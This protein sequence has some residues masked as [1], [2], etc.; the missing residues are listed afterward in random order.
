MV[1][2]YAYEK[3]RGVP[4]STIWN[5]DYHLPLWQK[6]FDIPNSIPLLLV[7][8][9]A[10]IFWKKTALALMFAS[11]LIH[12]LLDFTVHHD[13]AHRHFFPLSNFR[14]ASPI[15]YWDPKFY[16]K[17]FGTLEIFLFVAGSIYLWIAKPPKAKILQLSRLRLVVLMTSI[18]YAGFFYFVVTHWEGV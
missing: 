17:I 18:T 15:S 16:G 1:L 9:C 13:D 6:I 11:M 2:F 14:F 10:T 5:L 4:E 3:L 12:C 8:L 7:A